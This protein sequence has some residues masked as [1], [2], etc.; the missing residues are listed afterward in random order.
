M[1]WQTSRFHNT[2]VPAL[3]VAGVAFQLLR[4]HVCE[5][6]RVTSRSMEPTLHGDP[7]SGDIVVVDRLAWL[8]D[9]PRPGDLVV[10]RNP[11]D[12]SQN[13]LVKR[14]VAI[15]PAF[16][17]FRGGDVFL[18]ESR[19][20]L[21]RVV[22]DPIAYRS[23]RTVHARLTGRDGLPFRDDAERSRVL[24]DSDDPEARVVVLEPVA[25]LDQLRAALAAESQDERSAN[26]PPD[27]FLPGH[28][29]LAEPVGNDF[30][31][32]RGVRQH[33]SGPVPRDIGIDLEL[34]VDTCAGLQLVYE[35]AEHYFACTIASDG[36]GVFSHY[37]QAL[38]TFDF[39][40]I[41]PRTALRISFGYLDGRLFVTRG[42][43]LVAAY[44]VDLPEQ[45][46][47]L[48][49]RD[50]RFVNQ[51][52]V[53]IAG[54]SSA[55]ISAFEVFRDSYY[56]AT[57]RTYHVEHGQIFVLGDNAFDSSDSRDRGN[58]P[59]ELDDLVGRPFAVIGPMERARWLP[60]Y[61]MT[62]P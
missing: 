51:L 37:G 29:S 54:E 33:A 27:R 5:R 31:D 19:Q 39:G 21:A 20:S 56:D 4:S 32:A 35:Y 34:E 57:S 12:A 41:A 59:F 47:L 11:D 46:R 45:S 18:G 16:V 1:S 52:H 13:H 15:G 6:Y 2:A 40:E 26:V 50:D 7:E 8:S 60:R 3:V 25:T 55:S 9:E 43:E 10:L 38:A 24:V 48:I 23:F 30:L 22:K 53:G 36:D 62:G 17:E 61:S 42:D 28:M 58:G 44:A 49:D 14:L